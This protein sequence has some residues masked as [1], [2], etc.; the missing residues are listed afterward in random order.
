M[1]AV[2]EQPS[3]R[4][5]LSNLGEPTVTDPA[6]VETQGAHFLW[7]ERGK[8][9]QRGA[10][11]SRRF[12]FPRAADVERTER[13]MCVEPGANALCCIQHIDIDDQMRLGVAFSA[14]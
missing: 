2:I 1:D 11:D 9:R 7:V 6:R 14:S 13:R 4:E 8:D 12:G 3:G 10:I 5:Y